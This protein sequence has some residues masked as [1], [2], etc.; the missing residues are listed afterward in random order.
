MVLFGHRSFVKNK[1]DYSLPLS[2]DQFCALFLD[3][4]QE[5]FLLSVSSS[6]DPRTT[7]DIDV[8]L[9]III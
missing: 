3:I 8:Q 4:M 6:W 2:S 1:N 5:K 9:E 7:Q